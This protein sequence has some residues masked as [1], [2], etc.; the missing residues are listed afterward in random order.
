ME[1][2][3]S[4][5]EERPGGENG[6]SRVGRPPGGEPAPKSSRATRNGHRLER[7][8]PPTSRSLLTEEARIVTGAPKLQREVG[9]I[10]LSSPAS[11]IPVMRDERNRGVLVHEQFASLW[12]L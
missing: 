7:F 10:A 2:V 12:R 9:E 8:L 5:L 6:A 3:V 1:L 4:G 11:Q